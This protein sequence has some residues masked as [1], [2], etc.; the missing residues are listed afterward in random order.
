MSVL[1]RFLKKSSGK[2][3]KNSPFSG[4]KK[5]QTV[6]FRPISLAK[7]A[8]KAVF[9]VSFAEIFQKKFWKV[10]KNFLHLSGKKKNQI[11]CFRPIPLAKMAKKA[12]LAVSFGCISMKKFWKVGKNSPFSGKKKTSR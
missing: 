4:K 11:V 10:E 3:R 6:C 12:V 1:P 5:N 8:K 2:W 9:N 7:I